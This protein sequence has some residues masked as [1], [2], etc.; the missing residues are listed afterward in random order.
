MA[1]QPDWYQSQWS[2]DGLE[3]NFTPEMWK[4]TYLGSFE[5]P[6]DFGY[7]TERFY[8][9]MRAGMGPSV[10]AAVWSDWS[11]PVQPNTAGWDARVV[12]VRADVS[13]D[14]N[15]SVTL[16]WPDEYDL[17]KYANQIQYTIERKTAD[18]STWAKIGSGSGTTIGTQFIDTQVAARNHLRLPCHALFHDYGTQRDGSRCRWREREPKRARKPRQPGPGGGQPV[19]HAVGARDCSVDAGPGR[20]RLARNSARCRYREPDARRHPR[21]HPRRV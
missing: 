9:R 8:F 2:P 15:P 18:A 3:W 6:Q 4:S 21:V 16:S 7:T 17:Q 5:G 19:Q 20:R 10:E 14:Q 12:R 11:E 13:G 1:V